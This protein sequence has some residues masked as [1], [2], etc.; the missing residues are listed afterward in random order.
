MDVNHSTTQHARLVLAM[1][2]TA[3]LLAVA[4]SCGDTGTYQGG[5]DDAPY[6]R[7]EQAR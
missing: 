4:A 7:M 1:L 3:V 6:Y 5:D 2:V